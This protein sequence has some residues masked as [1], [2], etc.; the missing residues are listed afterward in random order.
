MNLS[1][2]GNLGPTGQDTHAGRPHHGRP[3]L[4]QRLFGQRLRRRRAAAAFV[5]YAAALGRDEGADALPSIVILNSL[6]HDQLVCLLE[7]RRRAGAPEAML[8]LVPRLV[9]RDLRMRTATCLNGNG[10]WEKGSASCPN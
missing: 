10:R 6:S 9:D 7:V 8:Q 3:G 1:Y 4:L 5:S 2:P